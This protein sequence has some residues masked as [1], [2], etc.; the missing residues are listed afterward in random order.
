MRSYR[1]RYEYRQANAA[2]LF[3][4]IEEITG[5]SIDSLVETWLQA[6]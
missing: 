4:I 6:S 1:D 3:A 5:Q 2:D